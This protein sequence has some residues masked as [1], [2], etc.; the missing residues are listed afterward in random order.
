MQILPHRNK[1]WY[2][3]FVIQIIG[4]VKKRIDAL[5]C[6]EQLASFERRREVFL[7]ACGRDLRPYI[8]TPILLSGHLCLSLVR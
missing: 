4:T 1:L 7:H 6:L 8:Y 3:A 2:S 5:L